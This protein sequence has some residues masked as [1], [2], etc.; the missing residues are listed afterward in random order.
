LALRDLT[1]L[2]PRRRKGVITGPDQYSY[3]DARLRIVYSSN[4]TASARRIETRFERVVCDLER[5]R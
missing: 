3:R 4:G 2:L 5:R 1:V